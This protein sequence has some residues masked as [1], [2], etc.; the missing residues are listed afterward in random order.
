MKPGFKCRA[1]DDDVRASPPAGEGSTH[2]E[3]IFRRLL[4]Q[5]VQWRHASNGLVAEWPFVPQLVRPCQVSAQS[6]SALGR[7]P[8]SLA[9][10][11]G[12]FSD[13]GRNP[14]LPA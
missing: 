11:A 9:R 6:G 8:Q 14:N 2:G 7:H 10:M 12:F 13:G 3:N 5:K 4:L 1:T